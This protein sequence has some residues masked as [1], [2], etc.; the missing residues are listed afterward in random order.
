MAWEIEGVVDGGVHAE[1]PLGGASRL[2][3]LHLARR[4]GLAEGLE[5]P[6]KRDRRSRKSRPPQPDTRC[7][8]RDH[9]FHFHGKDELSGLVVLE[10]NCVF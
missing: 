10:Q 5:E 8:T 1:K 6:A 9:G 7:R 4:V 2:E 3:P